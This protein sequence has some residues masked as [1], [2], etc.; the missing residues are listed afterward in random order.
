MDIKQPP[1]IIGIAFLIGVITCA[2]VIGLQMDIAEAFLSGLAA[3]CI[4]VVI[5]NIIPEDKPKL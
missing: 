5:H 1:L 2:I 3:S 4:I